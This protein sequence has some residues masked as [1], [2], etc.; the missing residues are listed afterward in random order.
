MKRKVRKKGRVKGGPSGRDKQE[1]T[2]LVYG[3]ND[4]AIRYMNK[5]KEEKK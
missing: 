3:S 4:M 2:K 1:E 5:A